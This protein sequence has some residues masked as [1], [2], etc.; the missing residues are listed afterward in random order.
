MISKR[1]KLCIKLQK[2]NYLKMNFNWKFLK[3]I[4]E[5]AVFDNLSKMILKKFFYIFWG[6]LT[7]K[8]N[9]WII[10]LIQKVFIVY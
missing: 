6:N 4:E 3:L 2:K 8:Q 5:E 1:V 10:I 7:L 9:P